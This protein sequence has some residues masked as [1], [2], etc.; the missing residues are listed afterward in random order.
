MTFSPPTITG[1]NANPP[2]DDGQTIA[3]NEIAWDKHIDKI[4]GPL[5]TAL[6]ALMTE[7]SRWVTNDVGADLPAGSVL[8][9]AL[10]TNSVT[11]V[12]ILADAVTT[13]KILDA[14]VTLA[15]LATDAYVAGSWTPVLEFGG[16]TTG[17]TYTTQVG[18]FIQV[19]NMVTVWGTIVVN[20]NGSATGGAT[21]SGLPTTA[22]TVAGLT[23]EGQ[24]RTHTANLGTNSAHASI[25][26]AGTEIDLFFL[27]S[28]DSIVYDE[29]IIVNT[30]ELY[31]SVSYQV[32]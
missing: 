15:K 22:S 25:A 31:F 7:L 6:A 16:A 28:G 29:T 19:G 8:A 14:N 20:D 32:G 26:S 21:V 5:N 13:A 17:I 3:S 23:F 1:F 12:K 18:R 9:A 27:S 2:E 11:A 24:L 30:T 4:G 10:A